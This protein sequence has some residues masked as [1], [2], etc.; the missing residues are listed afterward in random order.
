MSLNQ[1]RTRP[2]FKHFRT[3]LFFSAPFPYLPV[4][5]HFSHIEG[6]LGDLIFFAE[7]P[8]E[9]DLFR[10]PWIVDSAVMGVESIDDQRAAWQYGRRFGPSK[11]G[12]RQAVRRLRYKSARLASAPC[13]HSMLSLC[14]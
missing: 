14:R 9:R 8:S 12:K 5:H 2:L 7:H 11:D 3:A 1:P 4:L 10:I 13:Q 6:I